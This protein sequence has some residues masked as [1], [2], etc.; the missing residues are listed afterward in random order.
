MNLTTTYYDAGCSAHYLEDANN[1]NK[2]GT[3]NTTQKPDKAVTLTVNLNGN[4]KVFTIPTI[5]TTDMPLESTTA[6]NQ[7]SNGEGLEDFDDYNTTDKHDYNSTNEI[8]DVDVDLFGESLY[9]NESVRLIVCQ[10]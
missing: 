7:T 10:Q 3:I 1:S 6:N 2:Q 4:R 5:G 8:F 9:S